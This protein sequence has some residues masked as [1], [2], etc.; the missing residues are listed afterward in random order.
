M[1]PKSLHFLQAPLCCPATGPRTA[2]VLWALKETSQ[3]SASSPTAPC[4]RPQ[5]RLEV[6]TK[7]RE[8]TDTLTVALCPQAPKCHDSP[9]PPPP[10]PPPE[11]GADLKK[12][13]K[14][15]CW[16]GGCH[17]KLEAICVRQP[18]GQQKFKRHQ[19]SK[20]SLRLSCS[21]SSCLINHPSLAN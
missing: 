11:H 21:K 14:M 8:R 2:Q 18:Q 15:G 19:K 13:E 5:H 3:L 4:N 7:F 12:K 9:Q 17:H 6:V 20:R 10:T 16:V 1:G